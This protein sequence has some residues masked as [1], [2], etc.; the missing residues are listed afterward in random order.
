MALE[1]DLKKSESWDIAMDLG[2]FRGR[3]ERRGARMGD[4]QE[5]WAWNR[6]EVETWARC[7]K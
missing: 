5:S 3:A 1:P 2:A 4:E 6:D 7:G